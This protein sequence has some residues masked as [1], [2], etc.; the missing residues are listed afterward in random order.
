MSKDYQ[1]EPGVQDEEYDK[2]RRRILWSMPTGLYVI[3]ARNEDK[4]SMMTASMVCQVS[5]K[6][7]VIVVGFEKDAYTYGLVKKSL[8]FSVNL[9]ELENKS[10]VRSFV[11]IPSHDENALTLAGHDYF[12]SPVFELPVLKKAAAY[13]EC[14]IVNEQTFDSHAAVFGEVKYA[15]ELKDIK[16]IKVL[17]MSDTKMNYGG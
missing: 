5:V 14:L 10:L 6:P 9:I 4:F 15:A 8:R 11:K 1:I 12:L 16:D 2:T 17:S 3:G 13:L 7:K